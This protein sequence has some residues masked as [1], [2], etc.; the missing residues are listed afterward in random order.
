MTTVH[1][2]TRDEATTERDE[3][4][5]RLADE[6]GT[7]DREILRRMSLQGDLTSRDSGR[8]DRLRELDFLLGER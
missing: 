7:A 1:T 2:R 6:L 8:V 3:L 4:A 5:R